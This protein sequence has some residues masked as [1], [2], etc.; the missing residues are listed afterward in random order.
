MPDQ[1]SLAKEQERTNNE[2]VSPENTQEMYNPLMDETPIVKDYHK[3]NIAPTDIPETIPEFEL[4]TPVSENTQQNSFSEDVNRGNVNPSD[5]VY[6]K[7]MS[8]LPK[9]EKRIAAEMAA[10]AAIDSY[11]FVLAN[12]AAPIG[13]FDKRKIEKL[14]VEN[15]ISRDLVVETQ[16]GN[17][18]VGDFIETFNEGVDE[19]VKVDEDFKNKI[20]TPLANIFEKKAIG[21]TDEQYVGFEVIKDFTVR[22]ATLFQ[23]RGDLKSI[24][25]SFIERTNQMKAGNQFTYTDNQQPSQPKETPFEKTEDFSSHKFQE[26]IIV[27]AKGNAEVF[28]DVNEERSPIDIS[29][30]KEPT[31]VKPFG[32]NNLLEEMAGIKT[33]PSDK[34][35][36]PKPKPRNKKNQQQNSES[37]Q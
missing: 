5:D 15:Q 27:D 11:E 23:M 29:S 34:T 32:N 30:F 10:T 12:F 9:K 22:M 24:T 31:D 16:S 13:K 2:V 37:K 21:M 1:N 26:P 3:A 18:Q 14:F 28:N 6:N 19:I 8:E 17:M 25:E 7:S 35:Q 36:K 4:I 20:K 33:I